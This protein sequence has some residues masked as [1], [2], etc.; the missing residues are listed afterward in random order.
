MRK[1]VLVG[2]LAL[3]LVSCEDEYIN[4][5]CGEVLETETISENVYNLKVKSYCGEIKYETF[6]Y[7]L[8]IENGEN[9]IIIP[10]PGNRYCFR[11]N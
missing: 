3:C 1:L 9:G 6:T 8:D 5:N 10:Q 11:L 7:G 2:I 4:C